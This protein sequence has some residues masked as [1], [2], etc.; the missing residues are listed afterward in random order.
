[1]Q[2]SS[3]LSSTYLF[4]F[5]FS[6][7]AG[8]FLYI[9][10]SIL[11]QFLS[12]QHV[13]I[14]FS[15]AALL[16][17]PVLIYL[18]RVLHAS[19]NIHVTFAALIL[20]GIALFALTFGTSLITVGVAFLAHYILIRVLFLNADIILETLSNNSL[21]GHIRGIF[22]TVINIGIVLSPLI[23]GFLLRDSNAYTRVFFASLVALIPS[24]LLLSIAFK[25]FKD[26]P[27]VHA[28]LRPA[29]R[30]LWGRPALRTIFFANFLLRMFYAVMV[31]YMGLYLHTTIG[32]SWG[33]IGVVFTVMLLPFAL[34]EYPL[35]RFAD[36]YW[37]E[38]EMLIAGFAI[39][40]IATVA[41]LLISVPSVLI[42][43]AA[44]L[45]T[46]IGAATVEI[47]TETYFFKHVGRE[48][49]AVVGLYRIVEPVGYVIAPLLFSVFL[50]FFDIRFV[51]AALGALMLTGII[52][53][54]TLRD[55]K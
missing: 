50:M 28:A 38:K 55:T 31:V 34:L 11:G 40:G 9:N 32:M 44:L 49:V 39:T 47:M 43:S 23:V 26:S 48:D 2:R 54:L 21:T 8:L 15:L 27:R 13:G 4:A 24:I 29:L 3:L 6:L 17:V 7:H 51:F 52:P 53:T 22:L 12:A 19:G 46:R 5:L 45:C 30:F 25:H 42:W 36:L 41:L 10:S 16:S 14:L 18:P 33:N 35:G 37:G 20:E 1:M